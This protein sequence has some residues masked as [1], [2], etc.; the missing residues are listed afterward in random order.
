MEAELLQ[1]ARVGDRESYYQLVEPYK[2][3]I[4]SMAICVL[5]NEADAEEVSQEAV[6]RALRGLPRFRGDCKFSTWLFQITI[7]ESRVRLRKDRRRLYEPICD[8]CIRDEGERPRRDFA[9]WREIPSEELQRKELRAAL[10]RALES[11]PRMYREVLVLRDIEW[12]STQETAEILHIG[13]GC[14]KT[15]LARARLQMRNALKPRVDR[16]WMTGRHEFA[17]VHPFA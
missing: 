2:R 9:D 4:F 12:L 7:N 5:R 14:V 16:N 3:A 1:R 17:K 8:E 10:K 15:R 13:K 11:L 6:L